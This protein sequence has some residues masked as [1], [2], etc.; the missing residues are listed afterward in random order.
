MTEEVEAGFE[1]AAATDSPRPKTVLQKR[2][3]RRSRPPTRQ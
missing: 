1:T 3:P 2:Q